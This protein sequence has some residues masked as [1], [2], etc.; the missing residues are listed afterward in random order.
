MQTLLYGWLNYKHF[1]KF[2]LD[3]NIFIDI[4]QQM[5]S[6][7]KYFFYISKFYLMVRFEDYKPQC[8]HSHRWVKD[9]KRKIYYLERFTI[10]YL[11]DNLEKID[12]DK[13]YEHMLTLFR[14]FIVYKVKIKEIHFKIPS[15][16]DISVEFERYFPDPF[17]ISL[18]KVNKEKLFLKVPIGNELYNL[19]AGINFSQ[20]AFLGK[21]EK[22]IFIR[23]DSIEEITI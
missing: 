9:E 8:L 4:K 5:F 19:F 11:L 1:E 2:F 16:N 22:V 18:F 6:E 3:E 10:T 12:L 20:N 21:E 14:F 15:Q 13:K 7:M 23:L 17:P